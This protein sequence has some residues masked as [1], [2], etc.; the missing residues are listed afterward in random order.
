MGEIHLVVGYIKGL[1][2]INWVT[3]TLNF[4]RPYYNFSRLLEE[5]ETG[6]F[7]RVTFVWK[8]FQNCSATMKMVPHRKINNKIGLFALC[9]NED[10]K[11]G[12]I[13]QY[14]GFRCTNI[15]ST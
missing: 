9:H 11:H 12:N 7:E 4:S 2:Q 1:N 6:G 14:N 5:A 8:W 3:Q 10:R 13:M 15:W